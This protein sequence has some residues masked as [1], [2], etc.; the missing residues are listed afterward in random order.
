MAMSLL[1]LSLSPAV[2]QFVPATPSTYAVTTNA[3]GNI[4]FPSGVTA[5]T[6]TTGH[7]LTLNSGATGLFSPG[8]TL[9]VTGTTLVGFPFVLGIAVSGNKINILGTTDSGNNSIAI[10]NNSASDNGGGTALG[11]N[12]YDYGGGG[13]ALG[14]NAYD[15]GGTALGSNASDNGGTA[16]GSNAVINSTGVELGGGTYSGTGLA[17]FGYEIA[18]NNG[19]LDGPM[20]VASTNASFTVAPGLNVFTGS[21]AS[22]T[23]TLPSPSVT[24]QTIR[25][26]N[27]SSVSLTVASASGSQIF[28]TSAVASFTLTSGSAITLISDGTYWNQM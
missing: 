6:F 2:A 19:H 24:G 1:V 28:T 14:S 5:I 27:Q 23:G 25:I 7:T 8:S 16:L 11:S 20:K 3:S 9:N 15:Y 13:T 4:L 12:A 26:K 18:D 10:G 17:I 22:R 21:T